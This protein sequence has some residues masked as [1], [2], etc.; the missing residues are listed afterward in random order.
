MQLLASHRVVLGTDASTLRIEAAALC[1]EGAHITAI[2]PLDVAR[3]DESVNEL[4]TTLRGATPTLQ[5]ENFGERLVSPA[6]VN[7][8]THLALAFLRAFSFVGA[9]EQ[10]VEKGFFHYESALTPDDVRAFARMG[11]Y[12]SLLH[13]VG[14][15]WDHYYYGEAV[16][17]ALCDTGLCGV[18]APTLQD[19]AGPGSKHWQ[20]ALDESETIAKDVALAARGIFAALGPHASDT[21]SAALWERCVERAE[22]LN[23]PI[24][25]HLAQSYEEYARALDHHGCSPVQWLQR[26]GVLRAQVPLVFAHGLYTSASDLDTLA[27]SPSTLVYCP[28]SQAIF[29]FVAPVERW[30][31]AGLPWVVAT[32]CA[33]SNDSM[34]VQKELRWAA[35]Q[36]LMSLG[37]T[38][39]YESFFT[40]PSAASARGLWRE[41]Q[42]MQ[43]EGAAAREAS[44]LL[45]KVWTLPGKLHP[46]CPVGAIA[47]GHL[48]NLIVWEQE[49]PCFWPSHQP[50]R[51]LALGDTTQ[52]IFSLYCGGQRIG[53]AGNFHASLR[54]SSTYRDARAEAEARLQKL[55]RRVQR[56]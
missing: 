38:P 17:A 33:A 43:Q 25:A 39:A 53:E 37:A 56:G 8:H 6:F 48:A 54:G 18:I 31:R 16:A 29:G 49:D 4:V 14:F 12:E 55:M 19:L 20:R 13:G 5:V 10:L 11:A 3:Y 15:V 45:A 36:G 47:S 7:A 28:S 27:Q 52:A 26:I 32:D 30:Q 35:A 24:H 23:L 50:L 1:I 44:A 21:V 41:W 9:R 2:H 22:A 34:N 40:Q 51:D 42:A 46:A